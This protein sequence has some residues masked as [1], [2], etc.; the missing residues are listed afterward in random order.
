MFVNID[1]NFFINKKLTQKKIKKCI[2]FV[3]NQT[4]SSKSII[5]NAY[6]L[7]NLKKI[8]FPKKINKKNIDIVIKTK[9]NKDYKYVNLNK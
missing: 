7:N 2:I 8:Y 3:C 6:K 5:N 4:N 1:E 9:F